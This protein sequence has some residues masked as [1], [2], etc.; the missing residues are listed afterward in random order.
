[1]FAWERFFGFLCHR[2]KNPAAPAASLVEGFRS[3]IAGVR[4]FE[5]VEPKLSAAYLNVREQFDR[6][7]QNAF[8][9]TRKCA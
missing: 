7:G 2:I 4:A 5:G 9:S 8:M 1:M 6:L 3:F